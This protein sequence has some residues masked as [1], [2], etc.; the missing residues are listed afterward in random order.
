LVDKPVKNYHVLPDKKTGRTGTQGN[1][2]H[3]S[4]QDAL[5]KKIR[6]TGCS[7]TQKSLR[8]RTW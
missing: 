6:F 3:N 8:S 5:H 7:H 1:N 4:H 2:H